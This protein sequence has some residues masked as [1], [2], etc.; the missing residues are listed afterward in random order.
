MPDPVLPERLA[1]EVAR[2]ADELRLAGDSDRAA[3]EKRYL[4]SELEHYGVPVPRIRRAVKEMAERA[5][6]PSRSELVALADGLW[7]SGVHEL[8]MA[9]V[10]AL[11]LG[12]DRLTVEDVPFLERLV[13]EA[14]T[15][16]LVDPLAIQVLGPV[17]GRDGAARGRLL[18]GWV[19]DGDF[20][21]RR[22]ALLALLLPVRSGDVEA[23]AEFTALADQLLEDRQF[24]VAKAIGWVLRE[25]TKR[26]PDEVFRW[27]L[28]RAGR[29]TRLTVREAAKNLAP[30]RKEALLQ[31]Q[32]K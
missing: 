2:L 31:A 8:R 19:R 4:K 20:W 30:E 28:P 17:I 11:V 6:E 24:F 3:N 25:G 5:G 27:L 29:A 23:F 14:G 15:W 13:R 7:R 22:S 12:R 16:A 1:V 26:L 21:V 32:A 18:P 10:E 9:A